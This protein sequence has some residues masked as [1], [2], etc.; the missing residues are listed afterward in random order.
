MN[1]KYFYELN[2]I[3]KVNYHLII[4]FISI[5]ATTINAKDYFAESSIMNIKTAP[6]LSFHPF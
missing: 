1:L 6:K 3:K 5:A 2:G 4:S